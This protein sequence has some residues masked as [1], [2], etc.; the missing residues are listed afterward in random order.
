MTFAFL[1][2]IFSQLLFSILTVVSLIMIGMLLYNDY[3]SREIL[4][5]RVK[6]HAWQTSETLI[7]KI[8]GVLAK[9]EKIP[10]NLAPFVQS[11]IDDNSGLDAILKIIM[12][13][14]SDIFGT[15]IALEKRNYAPYRFRSSKGVGYKNLAADRTYDYRSKNWY[16]GVVDSANAS[17]SPPYFDDEGGNILMATY[18]VPIH[19]PK[20]PKEI[21]GVLTVDISLEWLQ[22]LFS[23]VRLFK[24]GFAFIVD[25]DGTFVTHPNREFINKNSL[26]KLAVELN[27]PYLIEIADEVKKGNSGSRRVQPV[28]IS[29]VSWLFYYPL[30]RNGWS[31]MI[32][33]PE[34]ELYA[35]LKQ[36][37]DKLL[38]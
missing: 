31:L 6:D 27:Q 7:N 17:W 30:K 13:N 24:S 4:L 22:S 35:D 15:S 37:H 23:S 29:K 12:E 1:R 18:S 3:V 21:E 34:D 38:F 11:S 28:S 16:R 36:L 5:T 26:R 2:T 8:D 32:I 19:S 33:F 14:N 10:H 25:K 20:N 9:V